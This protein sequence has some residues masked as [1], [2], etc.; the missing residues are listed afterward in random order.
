MAWTSSVLDGSIDARMAHTID[1]KQETI[2]E[3]LDVDNAH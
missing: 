3:A 2:A 1:E